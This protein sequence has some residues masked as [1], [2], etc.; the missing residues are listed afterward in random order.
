M[1]AVRLVDHNIYLF[2]Y[3]HS[4]KGTEKNE[5]KKTDNYCKTNKQEKQRY[6]VPIGL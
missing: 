4:A 2:I 5:E 3:R 6:C 1:H